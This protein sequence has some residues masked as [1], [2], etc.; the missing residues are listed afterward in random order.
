MP[1]AAA[2]GQTLV[3]LDELNE[4]PDSSADRI[5]DFVGKPEVD[6]DF[7]VTVDG[8]VTIRAEDLA[9]AREVQ[10]STIPYEGIGVGKPLTIVIESIY[11]GDYP[12]S[13]PWVP[14]I[15]RG[16]VLVTSAHKAFE[17]FD[18]APRAVHL[19]EDDAERRAFLEPKATEQGSPLVY[20][21]PAVTGVSILFSVELSLDR[22]FSKE[23][24]DALGKAVSAAGALP[25][26]APAAPYLV[27]GGVAIPIAM[28]AVNMLARPQT[29]FGEHVEL[30][31][32]RPGVE[33]AQPGALVLYG[34][35]D[36]RA[37]DGYKLGHG[38]VLRDTEG[39]PY[40]GELPYVVISLDGTEQRQFDEWSATAASA[41]LLERFF[42][43]DQL[44]SKALEVMSES[45]VFYND[46]T[47][48]QKAA[49]ALEDIKTMK[50]PRKRQQEELLKAYL[51]NIKT[52]EIRETVERN[53]GST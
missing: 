46:M 1:I 44:L 3:G 33:L 40:R 25:V 4:V 32:A 12:D 11:L 21:S 49:E 42:T 28:K 36:D 20:Y 53:G 45:M 23:I 43:S 51:K 29:L 52:K 35:N 39:A 22:D 41:A 8:D 30:N 38:F 10:S 5:R 9:R 15:D 13:M 47:Y 48:R 16:D 14:Y 50:G 6:T 18:A 17:S 34:G 19:L 31:F 2:V 24:G 27:A 7:T 26:F 37:F